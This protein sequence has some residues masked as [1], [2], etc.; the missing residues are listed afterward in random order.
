MTNSLTTVGADRPAMETRLRRRMAKGQL[1]ASLVLLML[2]ILVVSAHTYVYRTIGPID[3]L[4]HIDYADSMAHGHIPVFPAP[5]GQHALAEESCRGLD[6][7]GGN[8]FPL[9]ACGATPY[10][11]AK[12]QEGGL[13]TQA[14]H[15][16]LYYAVVGP[17]ARGIASLLRLDSVVDVER[18]LGGLWFGAGLC[19]A[20]AAAV[21]VGV[22]PWVAALPLALVVAM[23]QMIYAHSSVDNDVSA[24]FV[25]A[26]ALWAVTRDSGSRRFA[27]VLALIGVIAGL[28]KVTNGFGIALAALIAFLVP[29][30]SSSAREGAVTWWRR[31]RPGLW[32]SL[33]YLV[34]T[35]A[36]QAYF[37][38]T[39]LIAP[40]DLSI[41]NRFK[42]DSVT[43]GSVLQNIN[44]YADPFYT[45][46][47]S[48]PESSPAYIAP[49]FLHPLALALAFLGSSIFFVAVY[50]TWLRGRPSLATTTGR[51]TSLVLV[52]AGPLQ[53]LAVYIATSAGYTQVRYAWSIVPAYAVVT[54]LVVRRLGQWVIAGVV[55]LSLGCFAYYVA[56]S[57]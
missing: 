40:K 8:S 54:A 12:Y 15:P 16:P 26:L 32:M 55:V 25:G 18:L 39:R 21:R 19:L 4:Q 23:P 56:H 41:F 34:A 28:T 30:I 17:V 7:G 31:V 37:V 45:G 22:K 20:L 14:F 36:W 29:T 43:V 51:L 52:L 49:Q 42:P 53:F 6:A 33:G 46:Q 9:P 44:S 38:K 24:F 35:V 11:N 27:F 57:L 13:S 48:T 10:D 2:S 50:S 5:I 3:E 47:R 1:L